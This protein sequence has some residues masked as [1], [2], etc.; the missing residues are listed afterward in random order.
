[1]TFRKL[2]HYKCLSCLKVHLYKVINRYFFLNWKYKFVDPTGFWYC[3][4]GCQRHFVENVCISPGTPWPHNMWSVASTV[5]GP[6]S[7]TFNVWDCKSD[8]YLAFYVEE[9]HQW[10]GEL[11][12]KWCWYI[13]LLEVLTTYYT[14]VLLLLLNLCLL[15]FL[16][17]LLL[18]IS[19]FSHFYF[20]LLLFAPPPPSPIFPFP[21]LQFC[22]S[23]NILFSMFLPWCW[24][25]VPP[26]STA[27]MIMCEL[28]PSRLN[29]VCICIICRYSW[30]SESFGYC[31]HIVGLLPGDRPVHKFHV[32]QGKP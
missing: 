2:S 11:L 1:M 17:C 22:L 25:A 21:S 26:L 31:Y 4:L 29:Y 24:R 5:S 23:A 3:G 20:F 18:L 14:F 10:C 32:D 15:P 9:G 12:W 27:K 6:S 16:T 19:S 13:S 8:P 7:S 28:L 30:D